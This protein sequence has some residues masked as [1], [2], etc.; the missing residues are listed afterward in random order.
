M[1]VVAADKWADWSLLPPSSA[2]EQ[3][4]KVTVEVERE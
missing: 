1:S 3:A 2:D 4:G